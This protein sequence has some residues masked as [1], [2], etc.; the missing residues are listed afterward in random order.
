MGGG[1]GGNKG[2][3]TS[4]DLLAGGTVLV[5]FDPSP[6]NY[7]LLALSSSYDVAIVGFFRW[8]QRGIPWVNGDRVIRRIPTPGPWR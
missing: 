5:L 1:L 6:L 4:E 7:L 8:R 2:W 3:V